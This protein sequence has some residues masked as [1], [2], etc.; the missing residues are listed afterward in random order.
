M[1]EPDRTIGHAD[2]EPA[3]PP[4]RSGW[5][6]ALLAVPILCCAGSGLLAAIGIGSVGALLAAGTGQAVLAV[7]LTV[8]VLTTVAGLVA[9]RRREPG[10][11]PGRGQRPA[12]RA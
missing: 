3:P 5:W 2:P 9:R 12:T 6:L 7:V 4:Q 11:R 8:A 10:S 1:T